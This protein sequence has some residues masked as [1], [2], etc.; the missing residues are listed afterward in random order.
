MAIKIWIRSFIL[1]S[2][3]ETKMREVQ[4]GR[5]DE[6]ADRG[7]PCGARR[8][9]PNATAGSVVRQ[10]WS[11]CFRVIR[12]SRSSEDSNLVGSDTR[13]VAGSAS[14]LPGE[15][16]KQSD[17]DRGTWYQFPKSQKVAYPMPPA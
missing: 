14:A 4:K 6:R 9:I 17:E 2:S 10:E 13:K 16:P 5:C 15:T 3:P 1:A 11:L 7:E 8:C 12:E